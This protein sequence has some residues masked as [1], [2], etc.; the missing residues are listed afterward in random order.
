MRNIQWIP[1]LVLPLLLGVAALVILA[2]IMLTITNSLM[3]EQE[4]AQNY[5][6]I[7]QMIDVAAGGTN[8]FIN[9]KILP[10]WITFSQYG[11]VLIF[12]TVFLKMFWNSAALVVPIV[13]G[14]VIV[15]SL[16]AYAFAKLHFFGRDKLFIVYL[17][18]MLM[19]FQVT[20]VP[21]KRMASSFQ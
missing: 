2:P 9:L 18:T 17:M 21:N 7:G 6:G 20:L 10:D 4:L 14:Q 19:P 16:A 1:K 12:S 13:V 3:T 11:Q 15:A 8:R 5:G